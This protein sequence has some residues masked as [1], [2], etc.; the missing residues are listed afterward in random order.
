V[1]SQVK[2]AVQFYFMLM[3]AISVIIHFKNVEPD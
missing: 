1:Q 2:Y 3:L